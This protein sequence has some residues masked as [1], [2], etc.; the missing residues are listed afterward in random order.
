MESEWQPSF[1]DQW[2]ERAIALDRNYRESRR[3]EKR[4]RRQREQRPQALRQN[5][6][7]TQQ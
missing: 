7:E 1:I 4:L 3:E 5:N 2:Y 6:Q